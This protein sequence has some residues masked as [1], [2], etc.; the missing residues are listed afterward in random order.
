M[1]VHS[2]HGSHQCG[3][4]GCETPLHVQD[5]QRMLKK[6]Y[7]LTG[8]LRLGLNSDVIVSFFLHIIRGMIISRKFAL[9]CFVAA[10]VVL[11]KH[12][13][14]DTQIQTPETG[15]GHCEL[16]SGCPRDE[17]MVHGDSNESFHFV[18]DV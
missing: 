10:A 3:K 14:C 13:G 5:F 7:S 15:D 18:N 4:G 9:L 12:V 8:V 17:G 16:H 2:R 6:N 11:F 1:S